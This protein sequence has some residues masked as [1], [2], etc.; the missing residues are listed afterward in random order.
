MDA[1]DSAAGPVAVAEMEGRLLSTS[2]ES[3]GA[4]LVDMAG[5]ALVAVTVVVVIVSSVIE[6]TSA[7]FSS[8]RFTVRSADAS[9]CS[10]MSTEP[11]GIGAATT[12][13]TATPAVATVEA[14]VE[15]AV[16]I[17]VDT[18][19]EAV[20]DIAVEAVMDTAV[21]VVVDTAVEV[22]VDAA[23]LAGWG[24]RENQASSLTHANGP[25]DRTRGSPA[26]RNARTTS[27]SNWV[28]ALSTSSRRAAS[29]DI[30]CL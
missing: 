8:T 19:V 20:V 13:A 21:E 2:G 15:I 4:A 16:E 10:A 17:A 7:G 1:A 28:P 27:G 30:A 9:C 14:A 23:A 26:S 11:E 25:A 18:A 5:V 3:V 22:V 29:R 12:V 6:K 24:A